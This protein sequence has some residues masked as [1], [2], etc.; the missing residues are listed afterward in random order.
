[1]TRTHIPV[2]RR[3][4]GPPPGRAHTRTTTV[5]IARRFDDPPRSLG[6]T[7]AT[8]CAGGGGQ[9]ASAGPETEPA[10]RSSGK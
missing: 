10:A 2:S 6:A 3:P 5:Q 9:A 7:P 8:G 4:S 1:M